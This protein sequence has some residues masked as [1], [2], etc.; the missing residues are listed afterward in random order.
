MMADN[1]LLRI[2]ELASKSGVTPRTIRFYVQEGL[3]PKPVKSRK[4]LAHYQA[5]CIDKVKAIK[6]AQ[7]ERFLPLVVIRK[8]LEENNF[9]YTALVRPKSVMNSDDSLSTPEIDSGSTERINLKEICVELEI[10]I[11]AIN[12][13][14]RLKW[15]RPEITRRQ[16][17]IAV[18]EYDFLC[19]FAKLLRKGMEWRDITDLFLSIQGIV[20][21]GVDTELRTAIQWIMKNPMLDIDDVLALEA[22]VS[23][24]FI[25][26]IRMC[27]IENII[28][29]I[30]ITSDN[31]Y[32]AIADEG[33]ALPEDETIDQIKHFEK[34]ISNEFPDV[35][36]LSDLALGYSCIGHLSQSIRCLRRVLKIDPQN[37]E[38]QV[39]IIWYRRFAKRKSEQI[40]LRRDLENII[41]KN[42]AYALG[43][44]FLSTWYAIEISEIDDNNEVL[45]KI[46]QCF[47]EID[48]IEKN[49]PRD[50]HEWVI[51]QYAKG[52]IPF[53]ATL[54]SDSQIK[55][56]KSFK[57]IIEQKKEINEYY[58]KRMPFFPNW[59]WPNVYY[60]Y[61]FSLIELGEFELAKKVLL[62][63]KKF[64]M[65]SPYHLRLQE[66]IE[67][68][69]TL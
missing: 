18:T 2:G 22:K 68:T 27:C 50:L 8:I 35:R 6:K 59:L 20:E 13:I 47:H 43:H 9:D 34:S 57:E 55:G 69:K 37:V 51:I 52:R 10:P 54:S 63:A 7:A 64:N 60:F 5:D 17:I 58:N 15:I 33:F 36:A 24:S 38:A 14:K 16:E 31:A 4:T 26:L 61:G 40:K 21:K 19:Q 45:R 44:V 41:K 39:R 65:V 66:A 3:L 25:N 53:V 32:R 11:E 67:K 28:Q 30:K 29:Q 46:N 12:K 42:P 1:S 56:T 62:D 48:Q 49:A 23:R